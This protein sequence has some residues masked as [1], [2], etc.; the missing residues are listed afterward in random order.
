VQ[1]KVIKVD[2]QNFAKEQLE[3]AANLLRSGGLVG[4]PTETV[5]GIGANAFDPLSI[6]RLSV[7]KGR[8]EGKSYTL[9]IANP[10]DL[11]SFV[12]SVPPIGKVLIK[13]F[14]PGPLT[15]IFPGHSGLG[16]GVRVPDSPLARELI[17]LSG[18]P[19]VAPSANP[20]GKQPAV[21]AQEVLAYFEG[22][23]DAVVDGGRCKIG[24]S[25]TVVRTHLNKIEILR[26]GAI[27]AS[28]LRNIRCVS[29][30]FVCTGNSCRSPMAEAL[31]KM[32][33]SRS[34]SVPV[35]QLEE[36]GYFIRSAGTA[37]FEGGKASANAIEVLRQEGYDLS[38]HIS[39]ALTREMLEEADIVVVLDTEHVGYIKNWLP[40]LLQKVTL[41]RPEGIKDPLGQPIEVYRQT[42]DLIRQSLPGIVQMVLGGNLNEDRSWK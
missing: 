22:E 12:G 4:F 35:Y 39:V 2:P 32:T 11:R 38:S 15:I 21:D 31:L 20:A 13:R 3:P 10:E 33:L 36:N 30:L 23:L 25:S 1:T 6:K 42:A 17:A 41:I 5:Y 24:I 16:A 9:H 8:Q 27:P 34:L 26:E 37:A 40:H 18:V 29:I 7:L 28:V 14:W 19:V